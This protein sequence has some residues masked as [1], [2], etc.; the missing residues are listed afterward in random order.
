MTNSGYRTALIDYPCLVIGIS[1]YAFGCVV[2]HISLRQLASL[3]SRKKAATLDR[4]YIP[5]GFLFEYVSCPHY[6]GEILVYLGISVLLHLYINAI[7]VLLW[8]FCIHISMASQSHRW[9][10][11][12]FSQS[13]PKNRKALIPFLF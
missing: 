11:T 13:Y 9:Y 3:R 1:I 10:L 5:H 8:T 2:Q 6:F 7:V 4:H 12:Q